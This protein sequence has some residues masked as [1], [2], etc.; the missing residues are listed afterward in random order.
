M[1]LLFVI[2]KEDAKFCPGY[3]PES[4]PQAIE[5]K[6]TQ[7]TES[8][9][10]SHENTTKK[11]ELQFKQLD[12]PSIDFPYEVLILGIAVGIGLFVFRKIRKK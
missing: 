5:P 2:V 6:N 1:Q 9:S 4:I 8:I 7:K 12:E 11:D 10:T 3:I